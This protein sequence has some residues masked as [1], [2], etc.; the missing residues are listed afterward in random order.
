LMERFKSNARDRA[1]DF[2]KTELPYD[3]LKWI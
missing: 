3:E 1:K 2:G